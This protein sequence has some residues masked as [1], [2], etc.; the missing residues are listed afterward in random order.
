MST[1]LAVVVVAEISSLVSAAV[2]AAVF[3]AVSLPSVLE[4]C[5]VASNFLSFLLFLPFL[6]CLLLMFVPGGVW[7]RVVLCM[8]RAQ[9]RGENTIVLVSACKSHTIAL[10]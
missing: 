10:V 9:H 6:L 1:L 2:L 3:V 5:S 8:Q 7:L 4:C